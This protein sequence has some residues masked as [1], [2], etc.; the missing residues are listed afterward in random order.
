MLPIQI[1]MLDAND[2]ETKKIVHQ[3]IYDAEW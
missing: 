2:E 3:F 1:E